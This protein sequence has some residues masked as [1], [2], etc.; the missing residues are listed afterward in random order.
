[1]TIRC[2]VRDGECQAAMAMAMA[3]LVRVIIVVGV[4]VVCCGC[5]LQCVAVVGMQKDLFRILFVDG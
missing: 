3:L 2:H 5:A 4:V 1:M